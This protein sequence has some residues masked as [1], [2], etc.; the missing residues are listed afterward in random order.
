M[1]MRGTHVLSCVGLAIALVVIA[2]IYKDLGTV[3]VAHRFNTAA[4]DDAELNAAQLMNRWAH[5]LTHGYSVEAEDAAGNQIRPWKTGDYDSVSAVIVTWH[6]GHSVRKVVRNRK[7][8]SYV[9]G[10]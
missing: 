2:A 4:N 8:L 6:N 10:E 9:F 7:T 5:R 1:T 3:Y